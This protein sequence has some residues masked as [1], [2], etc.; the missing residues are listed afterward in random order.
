MKKGIFIFCCFFTAIF[1]NGCKSLS[2]MN[3]SSDAFVRISEVTS[4][5]DKENTERKTFT[6]E[7]GNSFL[8]LNKAV[9]DDDDFD[10]VILND[11]SGEYYLTFK[12]TEKAS[13]EFFEYTKENTANKIA[14][15]AGE[16]LLLCERIAEEI[17]S[18]CLFVPCSKE[19]G[20]YISKTFKELK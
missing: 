15:I 13:K 7:E 9:F 12:F 17:T 3:K 19:E 1:F 14:L 18:G 6:D 10:S 8:V 11:F 16:K 20:E 4:V 2:F 5:F